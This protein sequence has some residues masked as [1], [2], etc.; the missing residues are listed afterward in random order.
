MFAVAYY[1]LFFL[2]LLLPV[3]AYCHRVERRDNNNGD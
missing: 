3:G 1:G 2:S